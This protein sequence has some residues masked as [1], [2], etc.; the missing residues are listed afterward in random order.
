MSNTVV[1]LIQ[2]FMKLYLAK[3]WL[4]SLRGVVYLKRTLI[5]LSQIMFTCIAK[6]FNFLRSTLGLRFYKLKFNWQSKT[7][8]NPSAGNRWLEFLGARSV[9]Q[10]ILF[11]III[12]L[13]FPQSR[14]YIADAAEIPGQKTLLYKLIGPG[15]QDF[16]LETV[17]M[18]AAPTI[19][20]PAESWRQG[21][22]IAQPS[23]IITTP[24]IN[25]TQEI[26]GLSTGGMALAKP[27]IMPGASL[28]TGSGEIGRIQTVI[29]VV[30]TGET[31]GQIAEQYGIGV[32]TILWANNLNI[33]SYIRPGDQLKIPPTTGV[34][35]KVKRGD[36]ISKIA[37]Y[38]KSTPEK[39]IKQNKLKEDGSDLVIGEDLVVPDGV[40]PAPVYV[41]PVRKYTQ[42]SNI[43]APPPSVAAPAGSG[44]LW[45]AGVRRITQYYGWRHTGLDVGGPIGTGL[46]ASKAGTVI[47]SQCGWNGGYGC[48]IIIDHGGGV[49]T[50]YAHASKL[51]VS[52]GE[53]VSQGQ[54]IATMGSTGRSTGSHLHF[55]VRVNGARQNP[56]RYIR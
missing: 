15:D 1:S 40:M 16:S 26:S 45:P 7:N 24:I 53:Y 32:T 18:E 10:I 9:L 17:E 33:R 30:Q 51:Y 50:L 31:I 19:S 54:T 41:A 46:Y 8:R 52:V 39:I 25:T 36:T 5:W 56:L 47:R 13:A 43:A 42:L 4:Y 23:T 35:H 48:Y 14:W 3:I 20:A 44:Y 22:V 27:I 6:I 21:S 37:K 49:T 11:F 34:I 28:P 29:H 2:G 55:E 12:I 38:Y